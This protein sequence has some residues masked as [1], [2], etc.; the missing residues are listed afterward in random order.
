MAR[1]YLRFTL[2]DS[3]VF[4][5]SSPSY[6]EMVWHRRRSCKSQL[7][8]NSC[9]GT[10]KFPRYQKIQNTRLRKMR[11]GPEKTRKSQKVKGAKTPMRKRMRPA[12][13]RK[14]AM[15]K[16]SRQRPR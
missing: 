7:G 12:A 3:K 8:S 2:P 9:I 16:T 5:L 11:R 10:S 14:T 6:Q 13:S 1:G 4:S 15:K